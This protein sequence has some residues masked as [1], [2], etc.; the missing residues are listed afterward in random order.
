MTAASQ[1]SELP[2]IAGPIATPPTIAE[3]PLIRSIYNWGDDVAVITE[4]RV[5]SRSEP[6]YDLAIVDPRASRIVPFRAISC[7]S[8]EDVGYSEELGKIVVCRTGWAAQLYRSTQQGW[9]KLSEAVQG[10]G[11][12]CAIDRDRIALISDASVYLFST[13]SHAPPSSIN[14][15]HKIASVS[16]GRV[17]SAALLREDSILLAYDEGE[18]GGAL[19]RLDLAGSTTPTKLLDDNVR[20]LARSPSGAV[21]AASGLAH[22]IGRHGALYRIDAT[23]AHVVASISGFVLGPDPPSIREKSGVEFPALTTV[24]GLAFEN[25]ERPIVVLPELGVF[26]L[27]DDQFT[28]RYRGT[29][30]VHYEE[31]LRGLP[32]IV[33][34]SPAGLVTTKS[35]DL[36]VASQSVGVFW[37]RWTGQE[38]SLKQLTFR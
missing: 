18:F 13:R 35:G 17:P 6:V 20:F 29:L 19:Y 37:I 21:W 36:Y 16:D 7:L 14:I 4:K 33:T 30:S 2:Q 11:F 28:P 26:E 27:G 34:S 1:R 15:G 3:Q 9:T 10:H 8:Y 5:P 38:P 31:S 12:R 22:L 24:D 23:E 32:G 25:T